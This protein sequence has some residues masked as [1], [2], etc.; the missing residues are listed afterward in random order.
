MV[1]EGTEAAG[2]S[3]LG[4][5]VPLAEEAAAVSGLLV[6]EWAV[7]PGERYRIRSGPGIRVT[8][9]DLQPEEAERL[10]DALAGLGRAPAATYAG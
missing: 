2:D 3:G 6:Q 9:A 7:S 10:A 8:T 4:V 5:W 1:Q